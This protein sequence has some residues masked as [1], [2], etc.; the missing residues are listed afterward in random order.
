[1]KVIAVPSRLRLATTLVLLAVPVAALETV[2]ATRAPWWRLPSSTMAV[3]CPIVAALF[4][5][6]AVLL[7]RGRSW[8][9]DALVGLYTIWVSLSAW[10]AIRTHHPALGFLTLFLVLFFGVMANWLQQELGR[11]YFDPRIRWFHG[12]PAP[13]PQLE[14]EA[15]VAV[16]D[17][18]GGS[19]TFRV[20]RLDE[21]GTFLFLR[22]GP[23]IGRRALTRRSE[24]IGL[25]F[26]FRDRELRCEGYPVRWLREGQGI[27]IQFRGLAPDMRKELGD[28]VEILKGEGYVE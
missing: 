26:R 1:M 16:G 3:W 10:F 28:F 21:E 13:I 20:A 4:L 27:G 17:G 2:I 5:P 9:W 18:E 23:R 19:R 7:Q 25:K 14:C 22:D 6:I 12:L 24:R 8:A 11:S 15:R